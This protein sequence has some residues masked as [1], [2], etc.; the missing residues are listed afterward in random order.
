MAAP[1]M[2]VTLTSRPLGKS[3][4]APM[5]GVPHHAWQSYVGKLLRAGH[6]VVICDQ[7][8]APSGKGGCQARH[9][10]RADARHRG[11]GRL[12]GAGA[13]QLPGRGVD[14][15]RR[16]RPGRMRRVDRRAAAVP[17]AGR[18]ARSRAAAAGAVGA[19]DA[20]GGRGVPLRSRARA[21]APEGAARHR[22]SGFDRRGGGAAG[23][24]RRRRRARVPQ[25]QPG[26]GR[27][28]VPDRP[29]VLARRDHAARRGHDSQPG[30]AGAGHP[31]RP[32]RDRDRSAGGCGT[33]SA[34]RCA[35]PNRSSS[36]S[37][38][39]PSWHPTR[40]CAKPSTTP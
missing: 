39:W 34:R 35:T 14:A 40:R 3:G 4:R 5:C 9:H 11:R 15:R 10:A 6:K 27:T 29:H 25:D 30:A 24:R 22:V 12:P 37:P 32:H 36:A 26:S 19:A 2:G 31:H 1:I 8:E 20:T 38:P 28:G 33:G 21:A 17:D 18:A 13:S 16:G 23:D 7:V